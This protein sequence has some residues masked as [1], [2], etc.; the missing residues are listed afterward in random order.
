M[1]PN[2]AQNNAAAQRRHDFGALR[3]TEAAKTADLHRRNGT[4]AWT[5]TA[6]PVLATS[7][8]ARHFILELG[9]RADAESP[10][11]PG[12]RAEL[13]RR[14]T[15][16]LRVRLR[17]TWAAETKLPIFFLRTNSLWTWHNTPSSNA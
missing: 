1:R 4:E 17:N 14:N 3:L 7:A 2:S 11:L 9:T 15:T 10:W 12:I 8:A 5:W 13:D 6:Q 16:R